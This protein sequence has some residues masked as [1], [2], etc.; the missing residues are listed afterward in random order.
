MEE[1][2]AIEK[3]KGG[4]EMTTGEL[5]D[6]LKAERIYNTIFHPDTKQKISYPFR[7]CAFMPTNLPIMFGML[8]TPQTIVNVVFW[9][10][11]NQTYNACLNYNNRNATSS[12]T[13]KE[14]GIAYTGAVSTSISIALVGRWLSKRFGVQTGSISSQRF[15]NGLVSLVA[16]SCA[17]FLNLFLI[18]YNEMNK[19]VMLMHKD[20][21]YGISKAA[22][23]KAVVSS[24]C[25][26]AVLPIPLTM[27]TA[28]CWKLIEM[29]RMTPK[30]RSGVIAAD[31]L[32]LVFTLTVSMPIALSLFKQELT[33]N[34]DKLEP[35]FRNI[36]DAN[37]NLITQFNFNKGL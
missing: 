29:V 5:K 23:R 28:V 37:G 22:A 30:G 16:L 6:L 32:I 1:Y 25:T 2:W 10:W 26:R 20:R 14:L 8:C 34:K 31:M 13:N 9:Q 3:V 35:E 19:G 18:R 12:F 11:I 36:K 17:G 21:E 24:A 27:L 4:A 7:M 15:R 33:I